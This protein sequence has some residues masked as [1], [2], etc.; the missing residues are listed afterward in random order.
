LPTNDPPDAGPQLREIARV[1]RRICLL[2]ETDR[3]AEASRLAVTVLDP[4][5]RTYREVHG[6]ESLPDERLREIQSLEQ[7]RAR[8]AAAL[9]ELLVPLLAGHLEGLRQET[10]QTTRQR[11]AQTGAAATRRHRP[12]TAP[13]IADLL[14]GMLTQEDTQPPP[15][16]GHARAQ[17]YS[18]PGP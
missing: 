5:I 9:G 1:T 11:A 15:G 13:D 7:E 8:D 17:I 10:D 4:L 12:A 2:A 3:D 14:D 6:A 16:S 18:R